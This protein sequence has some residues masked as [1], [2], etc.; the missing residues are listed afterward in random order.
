METIR[1][2]H[3]SILLSTLITEVQTGSI[4]IP[5]FQRKFDW[6]L[7]NAAK[8][9]NSI[10]KNIPI[11]GIV[12]W[13]TT[14]EMNQERN[15]GDFNMPIVEGPRSYILDGQQRITSL[16]SGLMGLTIENKDF[17]MLYVNLD[18][19]PTESF[20]ESKVHLIKSGNVPQNMFPI[21]QLFSEDFQDIL[22][23]IDSTNQKKN[24][25]QYSNLLNT[26]VIEAEII[27]TNNES[28]A[29]DIF[30]AINMNGRSLTATDI[31]GSLLFDSQKEWYFHKETEIFQQQ[32]KVLGFELK[33]E[34]QI[35]LVSYMMN[36][37]FDDENVYLL[38]RDNVIDNWLDLKQSVFMAIDFIK[39]NYNILN[40]KQLFSGYLIY[41]I[42]YFFFNNNKISPSASQK[43]E[44]EKLIFNI[45]LNN[46]YGAATTG[47]VSQDSAIIL[48]IIAN[49]SIQEDVHF[50]R[51]ETSEEKED[52]MSLGDFRRVSKLNSFAL[53]IYSVLS[54]RDPKSFAT[55]LKVITESDQ[56][57]NRIERHHIFP[58]ST[59]G[60]ESNNIF[61][62]MILDSY[63]NNHINNKKPAEYLIE[64]SNNDDFREIM[65]LHFIGEE[66]LN[67]IAN[68]DLEAFK[69]HRMLKII[70]YMNNYY[71]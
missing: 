69:K 18:I 66:E 27:S 60:K 29:A 50:I 22:I 44:L 4:R 39:V 26:A 14:T 31:M 34:T 43:K 32:T 1:K 53:F 20:F 62:I 51:Y 61:N 28:V 42:S 63:T 8:L 38:K 6:Q 52:I 56:H 41:L 57:A 17:K 23:G 19:N 2:E 65:N 67:D 13:N 59:Y 16:L 12:L 5:H 54:M 48:K 64:Y 21:Y 49:H 24:A 30:Q 70:N 25:N 55:G 3:R 10:F 35:R 36:R 33:K 11:G 46:R 58:E 45:G 37:K 9:F 68:D 15:I 47:R 40:S 71:S 7:K